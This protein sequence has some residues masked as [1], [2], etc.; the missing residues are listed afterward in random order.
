MIAEKWS[1]S[2]PISATSN[3]KG[4]APKTGPV[5]STRPCAWRKRKPSGSTVIAK[6]QS[7]RAAAPFRRW[8]DHPNDSNDDDGTDSDEGAT[9][10]PDQAYEVTVRYKLL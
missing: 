5:W 1:P 10:Q 4:W 3:C 7:G 2:D 8:E 6:R 9:G